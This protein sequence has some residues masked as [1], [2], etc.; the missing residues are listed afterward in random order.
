MLFW[1]R[2]YIKVRTVGYYSLPMCVQDDSVDHGKTGWRSHGKSR[3]SQGQE[4][5]SVAWAEEMCPVLTS[6]WRQLCD[7]FTTHMTL[8]TDKTMLSQ[9]DCPSVWSSRSGILPII[10]RFRNSDSFITPSGIEVGVKLF[11]PRDT[12]YGK[13]RSCMSS[14][15]LSVCLWR[16]WIVITLNSS[17]IISPSVSLGC[18]LFAT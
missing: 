5:E 1:L 4:G 17:K 6:F 8:C 11:L 18:S 3:L 13:A 15:R 9:H 14:V 16:W 2:E 7:N 10:S 12:L